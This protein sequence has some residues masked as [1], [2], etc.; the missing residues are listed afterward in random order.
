MRNTVSRRQAGLRA[1]RVLVAAI[2]VLAGACNN[3]SLDTPPDPQTAFSLT[4]GW[5]VVETE[6][7]AD[8]M[9]CTL[10]YD[11]ALQPGLRGRHQRSFVIQHACAVPHHATD[12]GR[13]RARPR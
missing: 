3:E 2:M 10:E 9:T 13:Q 1:V 8:A 12:G 11:L 4:G 7:N 5:H 6:V